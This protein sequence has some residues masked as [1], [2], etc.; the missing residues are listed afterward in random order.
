[1]ASMAILTKSRSLLKALYPHHHSLKSITTFPFLSQEPQLAEPP[2]PFPPPT[3]EPPQA[4]DTTTTTPLP[5]NPASGSP[6]YNENWRTTTTD[7]ATQSLIPLGFLHQATSRIQALSQTLDIQSIK[8]LFADWMTSQR[9]ADMKQLFEF[10]IRALDKSGKPNKPDA[11]LYNHYLRANLMLGAPAG[12]LLDLVAQM[13]SFAIVPNTASFN[14]VLKAMHEAKEVQAADKLLERMIQTGVE[15]KESLPDYE[16]YDLVVGMMLKAD[17]IDAALKYIDLTLKSGYM[18][19]MKVFT[20]CVGVCVRK[21]RLD[22]L[23]SVIE[24]CKKMDENKALCPPWRLCNYIAE[25]AI[26]ADNSELSYYALEFMAKWIARGEIARPAVMISVDEGLVVSALGSAGRTY[27]SKLLDGS[28]AILKRSL[29][30]KKIPNPESFLGKISAYASLG[31]LQKAF[32][33]LHEFEAAYGST[34]EAEDLFSPFTSL[35]PLVVACSKKGFA[36]LDSVYYQLENLSQGDPPYKSVPALNCII[37]GCANIWDVDRAY[38]TFSSIT[39]NFGLSPDIHSYNALIYA[40]GKTKRES[41]VEVFDH[42]TSLGVTPNAMTYALLVDAHLIERDPKAALSVIDEMV[43][44]GF[45]PTKET[46]QKVRR[47]CIR[48]MDY[49]SDDKVESLARKF[50]IRIGTQNRR[51]MLFN[52]EYSIDY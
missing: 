23:V 16:S 35:F 20:E 8:N 43:S 10:W 15:N 51:D 44:A 19:S 46:L 45:V 30:Q 25:V 4:A 39:A 28:W 50:G 49:E 14:L 42:F 1:M 5:P 6:L 34:E 40:F 52:L 29:R 21:G 2:L 38:Q 33:T 3:P 18:M 37:L 11:S 9:W 48:Q 12:E 22:T 31:N 32:T 27:S 36:T 7:T 47:R 26:Q 17:Q 13:E 24:R 41:A